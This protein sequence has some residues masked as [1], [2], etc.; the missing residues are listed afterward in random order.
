MREIKRFPITQKL[1]VICGPV[2]LYTT[3]GKVRNGLGDGMQ[4]NAATQKA[5]DALEFTRSGRGIAEQ[6]A[7]G[8]GGTW[9]GLQIQVDMAVF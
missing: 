1:R 2:H 7:N 4:F 8:I 5:V 3:A 6:C 9:E